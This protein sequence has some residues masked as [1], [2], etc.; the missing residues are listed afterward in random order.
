VDAY[1]TLLFLHLLAAFMM[2]GGALAY[3]ILQFALLRRDRPSEVAALFGAGRLFGLLIQV[4]AVAVLIF[5]I[6]LAYVSTPEYGITDEWVITAIVLWVIA[7]ALG[8]FGGNLYTKAAQLAGRLEAE[9]AD[10]PS[11][12]L[13]AMIRSPRAA[14]MTWGST[15]LIVAILVLMIWK[16]GAL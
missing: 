14:L 15:V 2:I 5:G 13:R 12:E 16:P 4:G 1:D 6:W 9:G 10:A 8:F 11:A 3:H 7:V